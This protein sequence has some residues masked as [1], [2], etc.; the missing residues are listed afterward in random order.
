MYGTT[1][2]VPLF[3]AQVR[4]F[5]ALQIGQTVFVVGVAQLVLSPFNTYIARAMD[6]RLMLSRSASGC[7]PTRC[8]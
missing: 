6:L 1:Y 3:L 5:S 4:G 8:T 7:S 2:L